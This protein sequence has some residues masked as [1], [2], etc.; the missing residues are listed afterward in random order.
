MSA[1]KELSMQTLEGN[2]PAT[3]PDLI[4]L[5]ERCP[6]AAA[7]HS[8]YVVRTRTVFP[9]RHSQL[10]LAAD[11]VTD[12]QLHFVSDGKVH[13]AQARIRGCLQD[14]SVEMKVQ[15]MELGQVRA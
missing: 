5:A 8:G 4:G 9:V 6:S 11:I 1:V 13:F 3:R 2:P 15:F 12:A 7:F 10:S 14:Q